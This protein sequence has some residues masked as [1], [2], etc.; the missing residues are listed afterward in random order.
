MTTSIVFEHT[1]PNTWRATAGERTFVVRRYTA[2]GERTFE[3]W[4]T[5]H[6]GSRHFAANEFVGEAPTLAAAKKLVR[7]QAGAA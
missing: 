1:A 4:N 6:E 2:G 7:G 3:V 5:I